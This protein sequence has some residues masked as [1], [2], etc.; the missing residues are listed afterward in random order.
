MSKY[1]D[2]SHIP[3]KFVLYYGHVSDGLQNIFYS[4]ESMGLR[5][6]IDPSLC[7]HWNEDQCDKI[8]RHCYSEKE[9]CHLYMEGYTSWFPFRQNDNHDWITY[10]IQ[11]HWDAYQ[12]MLSRRRFPYQARFSEAELNALKRILTNVGHPFRS[13]SDD[14]EIANDILKKLPESK[15]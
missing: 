9:Y 7:I 3:Y 10:D 1:K 8:G 6:K 2:W 14:C 11:G 4:P 13:I 5:W 12:A 15:R